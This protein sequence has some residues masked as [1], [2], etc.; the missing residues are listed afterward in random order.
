MVNDYFDNNCF[1]DILKWHVIPLWVGGVKKIA[2]VNISNDSK[3]RKVLNERLFIKNQQLTTQI[4]LIPLPFWQDSIFE[5]QSSDMNIITI[6][7]TTL[8]KKVIC[9]FCNNIFSLISS[10]LSLFILFLIPYFFLF[11]N[12][13][14][15]WSSIPYCLFSFSS[16][17]HELLGRIF[18]S[19]LAPALIALWSSAFPTIVFKN[20]I[21]LFSHANALI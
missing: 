2:G 16:G 19:Q 10:C 11:L 4:N 18:H 13:H 14:I 6:Q 5:S 21:Q 9:Y 7:K 20:H 3:Q 15:L 1:R 12:R 17:N 8:W